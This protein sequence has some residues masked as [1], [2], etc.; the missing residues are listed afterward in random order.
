MAWLR[1]STR[2]FFGAMLIK[3]WVDWRDLWVNTGQILK[4][5]SLLLHHLENLC[6]YFVDNFC[7]SIIIQFICSSP[8][9]VWFWI[10]AMSGDILVVLYYIHFFKWRLKQHIFRKNHGRTSLALLKCVLFL[11]DYCISN[12]FVRLICVRPLKIVWF[13][14]T[15]I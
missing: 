9:I 15:P 7:C 12:Q 11:F 3:T 5:Q 10:T 8:Y 1:S 2:P 13:L 14:Y 4:I 6:M